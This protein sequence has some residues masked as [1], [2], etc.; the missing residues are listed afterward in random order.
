MILQG[1]DK[2]SEEET[3]EERMR[4]ITREVYEEKKVSSQKKA[5]VCGVLGLI[6]IA[7]SL[8]IIYVSDY[9]IFYTGTISIVLGIVAGRE[10]NT[11]TKIIGVIDILVGCLFFI[12]AIFVGNPFGS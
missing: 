3:Y 5:L 10:G 11:G 9:K 2:L 4:R 8:V 12:I 6:M 7:V 1:D